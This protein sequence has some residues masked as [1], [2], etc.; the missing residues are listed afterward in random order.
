[1]TID[2]LHSRHDVLKEPAPQIDYHTFADSS[3]ALVVK[4]WRRY[5]GT[6]FNLVRNAVMDFL[7]NKSVEGLFNI[8][9][10][11]RTVEYNNSFA[12]DEKR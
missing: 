10:P 9:F 3:V 6:D 7:H 2:Y 4:F 11:V 8:P 12:V 1:M 5:P